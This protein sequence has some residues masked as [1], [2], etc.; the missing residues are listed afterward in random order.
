MGS[1]VIQRGGGGAP[2][3]AAGS[4][5]IGAIQYDGITQNHVMYD[6]GSTNPQHTDR[7][8]YDGDLYVNS[9][10]STTDSIINSITVG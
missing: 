3:V 2:L 8:N 10:I 6:G 4:A 5:S 7:L 9:L 1:I